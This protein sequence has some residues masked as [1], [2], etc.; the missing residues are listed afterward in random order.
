MII[1]FQRYDRIDPAEPDGPTSSTGWIP[2]V[3]FEDKSFSQAVAL[4]SE[5][6]DGEFPAVPDRVQITDTEY[7]T[8]VEFK[9]EPR[10]VQLVREEL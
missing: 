1:V 4:V 3:S 5:A 2:R 8:A 9:V 10:G 7:A 6:L